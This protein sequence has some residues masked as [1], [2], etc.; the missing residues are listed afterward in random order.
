MSVYYGRLIP[1]MLS[2]A[3]ELKDKVGAVLIPIPKNGKRI[4]PIG[5]GMLAVFKDSKYRDLGKEFV[6]SFMSS[7]HFADFCNATPIHAIPSRK[8]VSESEEF[9]KNEIIAAYPEILKL[10]LESIKY[11]VPA[12]IGPDGVLNVN[13]GEIRGSFIIEDAIQKVVLYNESVEDVAKWAENEL[14]KVMEGI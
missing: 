8:N 6:K 1:N 2:N 12:G 7:K 4:Y 9:K 11:S 14:K 13:I 5:G 3:P 10:S